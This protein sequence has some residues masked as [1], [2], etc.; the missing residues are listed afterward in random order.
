MTRLWTALLNVFGYAVLAFVVAP[1]AIVIAASFSPARYMQFPPRGVS[2]RWYGEVLTSPDWL[3]AFVS[4]IMLALCAAAA[5]T[6]ACFLAA[7][8][9][10][11][12]RMPGRTLFELLVQAPLLLPNAALAM[13]L[14][15]L[16]ILFKGRGTFG[17]LWLA[18]CIM[19]LPFVYRPL[20]NGLRQFD[21]G[22]E[23]AAMTLGASP[24]RT[25]RLVTLPSI[26]PA[27][28]TAFAFSFIISF[29]EVTA[30]LFLVGINYTTLPVKILSDIQNDATPAIA[31]VSTLL[32]CMTGVILLLLGWLDGLRITLTTR[33]NTTSREADGADQHA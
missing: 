23:E 9:T 6:V 26:R 29:D 17:G 20:V 7:L 18:H 33:A 19:V 12:R 16:L 3:G 31:A 2:L 8:V 13:A 21:L 27:L 25:F 28:L 30:S 15:A 4:S 22:L 14:L 5:T 10:T 24:L 11:R 32:M 1:I